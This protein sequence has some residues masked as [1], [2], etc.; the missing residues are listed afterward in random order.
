METCR[1]DLIGQRLNTLPGYRIDTDCHMTLL[2]QFVSYFGCGIERIGEIA[3]QPELLRQSIVL[4][5]NTLNI[6]SGEISETGIA[7]EKRALRLSD[8]GL[9]E[10]SDKLE[11]V[12]VLY[13][14]SVA[15]YISGKDV[16]RDRTDVG[17]KDGG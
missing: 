6:V 7:G 2:G 17:R 15:E 8:D 3:E 9:A 14:S 5:E 11:I 13:R 4:N 1:H 16:F 10:R 12:A